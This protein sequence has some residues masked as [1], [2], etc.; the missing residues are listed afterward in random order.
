[1]TGRRALPNDSMHR[2]VCAPALGL[3]V[4]FVTDA[5]QPQVPYGSMEDLPSVIE[6][7]QM[8]RGMRLLGWLA[9]RKGRSQ[10]RE[11]KASLD[12][13]TGVVGRFYA[14]LGKRGWIFHDDLDLSAMSDIASIP[15]A[16]IA[17]QRLIAY[18]MSGD[19]L[20]WPLRRLGHHA[21]MRPRLALTQSALHDYQERR[22]YS[23]VLVLLSVV[24]GFVNDF[25]PTRRKGL[26]A[27]ESDEMSAWDKAAGHHQGLANVHR[28]YTQR[29]SKLDSSEQFELRRNGIVHGMLPNFDNPVIATKAWNLLFAVS[30]WADGEV[31]RLTPKDDE[32]TLRETLSRYSAFQA[33]KKKSDAFEPYEVPGSDRDAVD[34]REHIAASEFLLRW[35]KQQWGL[36]GDLFI[37]FGGQP[38]GVGKQ[39]REARALYENSPLETWSITRVRRATSSLAFIDV[40]LV[41][42][43]V[44]HRGVIRFVLCDE[45]NEIELDP[46]AGRW[47]VAPYNPESFWTSR[48]D[49]TA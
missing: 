40:D 30:D 2:V 39:A 14:I 45:N 38:R 16:A 25:D 34:L 26:H 12:E 42:G 46:D 44:N 22:F 29:V 31:A 13:I 23:C 41:V 28:T 21:A 1:M 43:G 5:Q 49:P 36:V 3:K 33:L 24:D 4:D 37:R 17:E 6:A 11:L 48:E 27:R 10:V 35:E 8:L 7:R 32:P 20:Q 15:D 19:H 47:F 18:Y 9:G